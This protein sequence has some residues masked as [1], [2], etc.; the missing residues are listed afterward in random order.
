M[1]QSYI[2]SYQ[3]PIEIF[4]NENEFYAKQKMYCQLTTESNTNKIV[5]IILNR[6]VLL[7]LLKT[8]F[9]VV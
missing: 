9:G 6:N 1:L 5:E 4:L 3:S 8:N 2:G 7:S